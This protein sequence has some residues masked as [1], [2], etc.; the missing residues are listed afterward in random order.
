VVTGTVRFKE[1]TVTSTETGNV[2]HSTVTFFLN[3]TEVGQ[4]SGA[5]Y[6]YKETSR[7]QFKT[8]NLEAS[9]ATITNKVITH[10]ISQGR[11]GAESENPARPARRHRRPG[12]DEGRGGQRE[13]AVPG[14]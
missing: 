10:L 14:V 8:P 6:K 1:H 4:T 12:H 3:G 11:P 2:D 13:G 7:I 5:V 9:Q